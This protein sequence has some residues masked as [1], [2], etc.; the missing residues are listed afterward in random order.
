MKVRI[1]LDLELPDIKQSDV[2]KGVKL[3]EPYGNTGHT[4]EMAFVVQ[5]VFD[6]FLNFAI[7]QHLQE[8]LHCMSEGKD[9]SNSIL[10]TKIHT[11]WV[12]IL[13]K[14]EPTMKIEKI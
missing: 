10:I 9:M 11:Q 14:A 2:E 13:R 8:A 7:R 6:N 3:Q 12:N 4:W 1:T 5:D